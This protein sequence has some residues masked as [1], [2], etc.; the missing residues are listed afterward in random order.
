MYFRCFYETEY[1]KF[2]V[3]CDV[4]DDLEL[5][6]FFKEFC[7]EIGFDFDECVFFR[8]LESPA[9]N[10]RRVIQL[11]CDK[12]P[13]EMGLKRGGTYMVDFFLPHLYADDADD[14]IF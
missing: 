12:T 6:F 11:E 1:E 10:G 5:G 2:E 13:E 4:S 9:S 7:D 14:V 3:L 8:W